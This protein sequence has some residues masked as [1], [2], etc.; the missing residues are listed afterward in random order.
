MSTLRDLQNYFHL[1]P[2][3]PSSGTSKTLQVPRPPQDFVDLLNSPENGDGIWR[4]LG[5][6]YEETMVNVTTIH[7]ESILT[8]MTSAGEMIE[9]SGITHEEAQL[10]FEYFKGN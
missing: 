6:L 2:V 8:A 3:S 4:E 7:E 5:V 9:Q 1:N 10:L